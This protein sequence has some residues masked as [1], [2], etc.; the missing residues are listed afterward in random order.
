MYSRLSKI[1]KSEDPKI[2]YKDCDTS[3]NVYSVKKTQA[4]KNK[5][6]TSTLRIFKPTWGKSVG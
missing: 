5:E 6:M 2:R 4:K 3:V 1:F